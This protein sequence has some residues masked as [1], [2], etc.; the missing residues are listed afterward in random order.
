MLV[1][2]IRLSD[3]AV[4]F[5]D[6]GGDQAAFHTLKEAAERA[7]KPFYFFSLGA[8]DGCSWDPIRN[9]PAFA[10]DYL[11]ATNGIAQGLRLEYGEGFGR[12]FFARLSAAEINQAFEN[13]LIAGNRTPTFLDLADE[14]REIAKQTRSRNQISEAFLAAD[15]LVR[16]RAISEL[17]A[18]QLY[19]SEVI[20]QGGVAVF[21]LPAAH[22]GGAARAIASLASWCTTVEAALRVEKGLSKRYTHLAIDEFAQIASGRSAVASALTLARKWQVMFYLIYQDSDQ[23]RTADGDLNSIIRSTCQLVFFDAFSRED[24]DELMAFSKDEDKADNSETISRGRVS[25]H[26]GHRREPKL[27]RN[28]I[29]DVSSTAMEAFWIPKLGKGHIE[30]VRFA[31]VPVKSKS[32]HE[33]ISNLPLPPLVGPVTASVGRSNAAGQQRRKRDPDY[34]TRQSKMRSLHDAISKR[35]EWKVRS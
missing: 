19:L 4:I 8:H 3:H 27:T 6:L 17:R 9:T 20:E 28:E 25:E 7:G 34:G 16:Y 29:L 35:F 21:Y 10:D 12:T 15:Q 23:L 2:Y 5:I 13:L 26:F 22:A 14:L 33:R 30:P 31:V 1:Q 32:Q 11:A 24:Q 18:K